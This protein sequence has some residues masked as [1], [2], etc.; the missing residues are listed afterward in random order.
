MYSSGK[1][2]YNNVYLSSS[3]GGKNTYLNQLTIDIAGKQSSN[4]LA[5]LYNKSVRSLKLAD[6]SLSEVTI[7][8]SPGGGDD[9]GGGGTYGGPTNPTE[10]GGGGSGGGGTTSTGTIPPADHQLPLEGLPPNN[11]S[12]T[13]VGA[14][15]VFKV[16]ELM[17]KLIG[18]SNNVISASDALLYYASTKNMNLA[19][20]IATINTN[21]VPSADM[22]ALVNHY[23]NNDSSTGGPQ[24][25]ATMK[26]NI[27]NHTLMMGEVIN[28]S[29]NS[30]HEVMITGYNNNNSW[31]LYDPESGTYNTVPEGYFF[32]VRSTYSKK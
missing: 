24:T 1:K 3:V 28:A 11:N 26:T 25:Y 6:I 17:S 7:T 22:D 18:P 16:I 31:Q 15:C 27:V 9:G 2:K 19:Q 14:M 30:S 23:F 13:Q 10:V 12:D 20:I 21:G 29:G 32:G 4:Q 8:T 5:F